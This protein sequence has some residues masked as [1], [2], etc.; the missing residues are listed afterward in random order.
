MAEKALILEL[1]PKYKELRNQRTYT[2]V[3]VKA[4]LL[5][6][7]RDLGCSWPDERLKAFVETIFNF[8]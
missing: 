7:A 1:V 4:I 8:D 2:E 3:Q 6:F 5:A